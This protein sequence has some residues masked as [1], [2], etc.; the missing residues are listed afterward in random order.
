MLNMNDKNYQCLMDIMTVAEVSAIFGISRKRV[1]DLCKSEGLFARQANHG[2]TWLIHR[3]SA[4]ERWG[5]K[6]EK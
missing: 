6:N 1:I 4:V 2:K 3:Q 5:E